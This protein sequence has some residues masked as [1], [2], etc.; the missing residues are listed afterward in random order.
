MVG[1][2]GD[3][4]RRGWGWWGTRTNSGNG[5]ELAWMAGM[6]GTCMDGGNGGGL[7]QK[8]VGDSH[9]C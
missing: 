9:R 5:E 3:S 6:G 8:M 7:T 4:H 1:M 2:V